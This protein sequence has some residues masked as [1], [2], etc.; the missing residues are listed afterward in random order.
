MWK[1]IAA[2]YSTS[3]QEM[4]LMTMHVS[5]YPSYRSESFFLHYNYYVHE[6]KVI[7]SDVESSDQDTN[8]YKMMEK[9][10]TDDYKDFTD[11]SN[12]ARL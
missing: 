12:I 1:Y 3:L 2:L 4:D 5:V 7:K 6:Q 8:D 11:V 9:D 10:F